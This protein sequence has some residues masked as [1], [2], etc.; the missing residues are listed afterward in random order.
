MKVRIMRPFLK[1]KSRMN[2]SETLAG[3][4]AGHVLFE[5]GT[6]WVSID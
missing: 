3:R 6:T 4:S 5:E 2:N 1:K